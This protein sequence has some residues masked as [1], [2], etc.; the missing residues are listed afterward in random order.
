MKRIAKNPE[1]TTQEEPIVP[2]ESVLDGY[3][4]KHT[5]E[6]FYSGKRPR[7]ERE[8][9]QKIKFPLFNAL[10]LVHP[11]MKVRKNIYLKATKEAKVRGYDQIKTETH[12]NNEMDKAT[13]V[14]YLL[15]E[16][17]INQYLVEQTNPDE[18]DTLEEDLRNMKV[19]Y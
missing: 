6:I 8:L 16:E 12:I 5:N 14:L 18:I 2:I 3:R 17:I 4:S 9:L 11:F 19:I 13:D 7:Q 1:E 15:I 10:N